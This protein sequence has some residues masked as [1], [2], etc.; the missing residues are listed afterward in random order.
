ML[1]G[2]F[3]SDEQVLLREAKKFFFSF[4]CSSITTII[5]GNILIHKS[6]LIVH[7]RV[8]LL[9]TNP[10]GTSMSH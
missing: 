2:Q 6:S 10:L 9:K 1:I 7:A 3:E 8:V 5:D 4:P